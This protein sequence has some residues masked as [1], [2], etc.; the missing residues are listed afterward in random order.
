MC[1]RRRA[2]R[3]LMLYAVPQNNRGSDDVNP[4][5]LVDM[6]P[7]RARFDSARNFC[8]ESDKSR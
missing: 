5:P 6:P 1:V 8:R 2:S 4:Y 3:F 7:K